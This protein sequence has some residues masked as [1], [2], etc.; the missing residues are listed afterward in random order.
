MS[1]ITVPVEVEKESYELEDGMVTFVAT[2][3]PKL[4]D[5]FQIG[6]L[7]VLISAIIALTPALK[8]VEQIPAE[9]AEDPS[10][11]AMTGAV[12]LAKIVKVVRP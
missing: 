5:G 1:K 11:F 3:W 12:L 7:G 10:A 2:V 9:A 8:G 4:K 6:D